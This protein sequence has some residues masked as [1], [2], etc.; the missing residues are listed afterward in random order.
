PV[1]LPR[2]L[3]AAEEEQLVCLDWSAESAPE[4]VL[5]QDLLRGSIG[6]SIPVEKKVVCVELF[7]P[8]EFKQGSMELIAAALGH[9]VHVRSGI[10]PVACIVCRS[11]NFEFL[12]R[13][14]IGN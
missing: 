5:S 6:V 9:N 8:E 14:G 1:K 3:I 2:S 7:I 13:I 12:N 11:L 4:L 10:S